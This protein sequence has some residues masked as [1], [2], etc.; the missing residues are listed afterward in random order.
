MRAVL[1]VSLLKP[2]INRS[3]AEFSTY[4]AESCQILRLPLHPLRNFKSGQ[5]SFALCRT[6]RLVGR[7]PCRTVADFVIGVMIVPDHLHVCKALCSHL[8]RKLLPPLCPFPPKRHD[9]ISGEHT[10]TRTHHNRC[11]VL[12]RNSITFGQSTSALTK[13]RSLRRFFWNDSWS[14]VDH[15]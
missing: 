13:V 11:H 5:F 3:V 12:T 9:I 10:N 7:A 8:A 6:P 15:G 2:T 1:F 14:A 4:L